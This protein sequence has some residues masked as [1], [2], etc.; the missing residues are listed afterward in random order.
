MHTL[1]KGALGAALAISGASASFNATETSD[2]LTLA[3]GRL[4]A[5]L[6]KSIGAID[7]LSLDGQDLLGERTGNQGIGPYLD[8]YCTPSGFYTPGRI[9]PSY[10][11]LTGNDT[12]GEPWGGIVMSETYPATGQVLEQ[13][14]FLRSSETGLHTFSRVAYYNETTPFLR[15][16]QELRTLFRPSTPLWT[17]LSSSDEQYA[18]LPYYNPAAVIPGR[19]GDPVTVQDATWFLPNESDPYVIQESSYFTK[20]TFSETWQDSKVHGFFADGTYSDDGS[21]FGAWLVMNTI[22]TSSQQ[23]WS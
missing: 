13:Y 16:L 2:R 19:E 18:P 9:D 12:K 21:T 20:Y 22:G 17:N 7:L 1:F 4:Y 10:K 14:W 11:L 3:N 5:S 23:T 8:C 15:N 6:D